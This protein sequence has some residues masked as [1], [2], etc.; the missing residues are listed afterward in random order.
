[1]N[2]IG[3]IPSRYSSSRLPGKPLA[4]ICGRP[5]VWWVY[6][7]AKMVKRLKDVYVA[8]DD[9]RIAEVCDQ[10]GIKHIMTSQSHSNGTE[11]VAEVAE[12]IEADIYVTIQG[13]EPL[14]EPSDIEAVIDTILSEDNIPC[15]T[16]K[17]EY[18]NPV[19][20]VNGTTPKVV[21]DV[22][23]DILLF[24]RAPIPYPKASLDY[25]YYK[26]I[27]VYAFKREVLKYYSSL[28]RGR[29]ERI[30]DIELLRLVENGV[31]I[32]VGEVRSDTVAVDTEKDLER[33]R[34][35][36]LEHKETFL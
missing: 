10:Y 34:D 18:K 25:K 7:R 11:R 26:P 16:L 32:R 17:T 20:V 2:I 15:A 30:E 6:Q 27:G 21:C 36:I 9:V 3:V 28:E 22:N 19:D 5:M 23:E 13:D 29:I 12:I 1:M 14:L 4:D 31:K 8:T 24:S 33:V 35:Y